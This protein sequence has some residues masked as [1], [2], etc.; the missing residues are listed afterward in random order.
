MPRVF[1]KQKRS[2]FAQEVINKLRKAIASGK[3]KPG[4]RLIESQMAK[5]MGISRF[6]IREALRALEREGLVVIQPFK[7]AHVSEVS[8]QE[9][10]E[11]YS[12][13]R[14]LEEFAI[15]LLMQGVDQ[16]KIA[17]LEKIITAMRQAADDNDPARV[18]A[19]D[20]RFHRKICELSGHRKLLNMWRTLDKQIRTYLAMENPLY[21][22]LHDYI[23]TH[24]PILQ[25]IKA[26]RVEDAVAQV[27]D[28]LNQ[29]PDRLLRSIK[30]A[31][32]QMKK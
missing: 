4:T 18:V 32:S 31:S 28:H 1:Q 6:P 20:L 26:G 21:S 9:I 16:K 3:L 29:V 23:A 24:D 8:Q 10:L 5:E 22:R 11:L 13:R 27:A 12:L 2:T 15:R 7:G 17:A 25:S 14:V 19:E 30:K